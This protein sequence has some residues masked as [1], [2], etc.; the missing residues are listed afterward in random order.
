MRPSFTVGAL[1]VAARRANAVG[2]VRATLLPGGLEIELMRVSGFS[3]GFAPGGVAEPVAFRVPYTAVRGL[4]RE[5]RV[6]YLSF[7]PN[8]QVVRAEARPGILA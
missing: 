7:D 1:A 3:Q 5:G 8:R 4:V 2:A 6:L